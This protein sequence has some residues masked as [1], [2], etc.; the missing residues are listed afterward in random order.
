M[1]EDDIIEVIGLTANVPG[2]GG[3]GG[4]YG[5]SNVNAHLNLS[6]AS[7]N[8]VL[9]WNGSDYD[10]VVNGSYADS[11][12]DTHLNVSGASNNQILGWNGNDYVW[13]TNV[14]GA[15]NL[16]A[17]NDVTIASLADNQLLQYNASKV[18]GKI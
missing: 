4:G 18:S 16:N 3:G 13:V 2:G 7:T 10:W 9:S 1:L 5:D 11:D 12:V 6:T 17:L 8:E 14:S 15:S